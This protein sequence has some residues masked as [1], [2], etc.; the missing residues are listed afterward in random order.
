MLRNMLSRCFLSSTIAFATFLLSVPA[1]AQQTDIERFD[2][3]GGFAYF[4][5]PSLNLDEHGFHIQAGYNISR[6]IATGFDY[7][8]VSGHNSLTT[9]LLT[10]S[11]QL[12][13]QTALNDLALQGLLPP[14][15]QLSVPTGSSTQTFAAGPELTLRDFRRV[16]FFIR[17]DIGAIREVAR[18][19]PTDPVSALIVQ[20]LAPSG[21]KTSWATFYGFG[22]G[23][24]WNASRH[25][26]LRFQFDEVY[27]HLFNDLLKDSRWTTRL[28]IG[29]TFRFG[30]NILAP[31]K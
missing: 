5:T 4:T 17:P 30:G 27:N 14:G 26:A 1:S 25:L 9:N 12:V 15:Y 3:Y 28:S 11:D 23:V 7:S 21:T 31:K 22:E 29:P 10:M 19:H 8:Y 2:L 24:D 20:G 18:P 16:T 13:I 6:M